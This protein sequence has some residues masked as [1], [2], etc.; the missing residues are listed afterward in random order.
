MYRSPP[1]TGQSKIDTTTAP[2]G[3]ILD[4][5]RLTFSV[6]ETAAILGISRGLTYQ[7]IHEGG[8]PAVRFGKRLLVPKRA[9]EN[10][11]DERAA[12]IAPANRRGDQKQPP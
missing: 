8:I 5:N 3:R 11:L 6:E 7:M 9:L 12:L 2:Q 10:L 4:S 1:M